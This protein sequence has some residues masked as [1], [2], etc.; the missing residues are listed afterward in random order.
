MAGR[1]SSIAL[2]DQLLVYECYKEHLFENRQLVSLSNPI[3]AT[4]STELEKKFNVSFS[5]KA[6][7]LSIQRNS[8]KLSGESYK[9]VLLKLNSSDELDI[10]SEKSDCSNKEFDKIYEIKNEDSFVFLKPEEKEIGK[11]I[12][13]TKKMLNPGWADELARVIFSETKMEC[14]LSFLSRGYFKKEFVAKARC[15]EC[16]SRM[17]INSENDFCKLIIK[18][19]NGK[20][21]TVHESKR[22]LGGKYK[23]AVVED[24]K[25]NK[26]IKVYE[27]MCSSEITSDGI[28]PAHLPSQNA[29]KQQAYRSN[30]K[31]N[32]ANNSLD[33]FIKLS[34]DVFYGPSIVKLGKPNTY[35]IIIILY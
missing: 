4:I 14:N 28:E 3:F 21:N 34:K 26:P 1:K 35:F 24:L 10:S 9:N 6:V 30:L 31:K 17:E 32:V 19:V 11:K 23:N 7:Y 12:V 15:L 2:N 16:D 8:Q 33:G 27:L 20:P 13:R 5:R 18:V 29:I 22:R 25:T